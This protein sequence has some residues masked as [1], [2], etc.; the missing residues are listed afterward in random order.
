MN[1]VETALCEDSLIDS[2]GGFTEDGQDFDE[3]EERAGK[4]RA[5]RDPR[6][7]AKYWIVDPMDRPL[8]HKVLCKRRFLADI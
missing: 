3:Q 1:S 5:E 4:L 8:R 7:G 6:K 2:L